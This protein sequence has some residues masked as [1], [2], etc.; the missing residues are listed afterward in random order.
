MS[1][2]ACRPVAYVTSAASGGRSESAAASAKA[3]ASS[4]VVNAG[5]FWFRC[6]ER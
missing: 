1:A 6:C 3:L 4:T 5:Q 2:S